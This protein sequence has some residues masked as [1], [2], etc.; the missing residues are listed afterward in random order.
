MEVGVQTLLTSTQTNSSV[1]FSVE[2]ELKK[3]L[4]KPSEHR[5]VAVDVDEEVLPHSS[6]CLHKPCRVEWQAE[7]EVVMVVLLEWET[8]AQTSNSCHLG[9]LHSGV[10]SLEDSNSSQRG[11]KGDE[12]IRLE[13][14]REKRQRQLRVQQRKRKTLPIL[15]Y[16]AFKEVTR[17]DRTQMPSKTLKFRA[18]KCV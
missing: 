11:L 1:N 7:A 18:R 2:E 8:W 15:S 13:I 17:M 9:D 10:A 5:W 4:R 14:N 3:F 16:V 6:R 12:I